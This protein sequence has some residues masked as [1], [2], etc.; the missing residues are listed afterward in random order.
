[1]VEA[2]ILLKSG[3]AASPYGGAL[4]PRE[5]ATSDDAANWMMRWKRPSMLFELF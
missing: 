4:V 5:P 1:L 2:G 3:F